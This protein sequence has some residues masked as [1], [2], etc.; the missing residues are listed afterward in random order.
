VTPDSVWSAWTDAPPPLAAERRAAD[1]LLRWLTPEQRRQ[2]EA[3]RAFAVSPPLELWESPL[4]LVYGTGMVYDPA[5]PNFG[6]TAYGWGPVGHLTLP[7][8]DVLLCQALAL[9]QPG[10]RAEMFLNACR[11][12]RGNAAYTQREIASY[13]PAWRAVDLVMEPLRK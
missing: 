13:G 9:S 7:D 4:V 11:Y 3:F 12:R 8:S 6:G 2:Y 1:L 5:D 10:A